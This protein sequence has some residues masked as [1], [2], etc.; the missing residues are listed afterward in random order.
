MIFLYILVIIFFILFLPI[1]IKF[2]ISYIDNVF[3][4]YL[5]KFLVLPNKE[6]KKTKEHIKTVSEEPIKKAKK[7]TKFDAKEYFKAIDYK[8][9]MYKLNR[10]HF[11]PHFNIKTKLSYSTSDAFTTAVSFGFVNAIVFFILGLFSIPFK[12]KKRETLIT[13]IFED[14][15]KVLFSFKGIIYISFA[16]IIYIA[17]IF[18]SSKKE[19]LDSD[20]AKACA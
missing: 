1:P 5:Y 14:V 8:L 11:K 20:S 19:T 2:N 10:S 6:I 17:Y 12:I 3:K 4:V 16:Q 9:V 15:F 18:I 13:P 7:K